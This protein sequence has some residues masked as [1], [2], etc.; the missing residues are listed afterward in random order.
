MMSSQLKAAFSADNLHGSYTVRISS[1]PNMFMKNA[2]NG[3]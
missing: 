3:E 1:I 2:S